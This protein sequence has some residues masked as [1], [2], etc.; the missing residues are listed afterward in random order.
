M[1]KDRDI[2]ENYKKFYIE[3]SL[4]LSEHRN[5]FASPEELIAMLLVDHRWGCNNDVE[6]TRP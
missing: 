6:K 2:L 3:N 1:I 4:W 5:R